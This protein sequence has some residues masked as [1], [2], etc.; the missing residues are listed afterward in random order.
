MFDD[1]HCDTWRCIALGMV[2]TTI[3]FLIV[4]AF[5]YLAFGV[6]GA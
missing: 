2:P 1:G 5:A 3:G 4:I 6:L